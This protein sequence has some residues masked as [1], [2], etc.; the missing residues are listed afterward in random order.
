M[1]VRSLLFSTALAVLLLTG[2]DPVET[3]TPKKTMHPEG[4]NPKADIRKSADMDAPVPN[5]MGVNQ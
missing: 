4:F 3:A 1:F 2:C 5:G